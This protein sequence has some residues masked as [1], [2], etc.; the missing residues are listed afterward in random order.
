MKKQ[1]ILVPY[2]F[3][4]LA[5]NGLLTAINMAGKNNSHITLLHILDEERPDGFHPT[6]DMLARKQLINDHEHFVHLLTQKRIKQFKEIQQYYEHIDISYQIE[7][8]TFSDGMTQYLENHRI[9]LIVMGSSGETSLSEFF[10]GSHTTRARNVSDVPVLVVKEPKEIPNMDSM[11]LI[12]ETEKISKKSVS[13]LQKFARTFDMHVHL[14]YVNE[15]TQV[16]NEVIAEVIRNFGKEH[17]FKNYSVEV[18]SASRSKKPDK[19]KDYLV[20]FNIPFLSIVSNKASGFS[21]LLLGSDTKE[22]IE[23]V[24]VPV[25]SVTE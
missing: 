5:N 2:D 18:I 13:P 6:A 1:N 20:R 9:D 14:A 19:I 7:F 21:R 25:L 4:E 15:G 12:L 17:G 3:T 11:L 24:D 10:K 16:R 8:G 23:E 22:I